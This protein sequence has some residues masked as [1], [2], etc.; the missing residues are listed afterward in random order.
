MKFLILASLFVLSVVA[1]P[2]AEPQHHTAGF[3]RY[4]NGAL[5]PEDTD[6]VKLA[7]AAHLSTKAFQPMPLQYVL[8][9]M[10]TL[11]TPVTYAGTPYAHMPLNPYYGVY[12][13][14]VYGLQHQKVVAPQVYG[15]H[16]YQPHVYSMPAVHHMGKRDAE[17][18]PE[19]EADAQYLSYYGTPATTYTG[20]YRY[21]AVYTSAYAYPTPAVKTAYT[22][23]YRYPTAVNAAYTTSAYRFPTTYTTGAYRYPATVSTAYTAA[24]AYGLPAV[25]AL[26]K[27]EA[28]AE[29][30]AEAEAQWLN[31]Y[32][33]P[34]TYNNAINRAYTIPSTYTYNT[35]FNTAYTY[36]STYTYST[37]YPYAYNGYPYAFRG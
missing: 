37:G 19:A 27:R 2:E 26:G 13:P 36:P 35:A 32:G 7:K 18:E 21:P 6:S 16:I 29:P 17:A 24:G 22:T 10:K 31:Y 8:K 12:Q 30:E 1:E 23:A 3:V 4:T 9:N 28:E 34:F 33:T 5:V 15:G 11:K 14:Q 20:T 25:H